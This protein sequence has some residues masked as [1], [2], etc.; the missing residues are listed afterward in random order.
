MKDATELLA[1]M[2]KANANGTLS[3]EELEWGFKKVLSLPDQPK[4][5]YQRA[6][7]VN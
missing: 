7:I 4:E 2:A 1:W 6:H 3:P 5:D